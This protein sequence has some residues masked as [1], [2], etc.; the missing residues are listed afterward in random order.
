MKKQNIRKTAE[1]A[2]LAALICLATFIVLNYSPAGGYINLGDCFV[3]IAGWFVG[4]L[5][6]GAAAAVGSVLTDIFLGAPQYIPA[7]FIVKWGIAAVAWAVARLLRAGDKRSDIPKYLLSAICGE[8]IMVAGYFG[9]EI[10]IYGIAGAVAGVV[11]NLIQAGACAVS[12]AIFSVPVI[13]I[14]NRQR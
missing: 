9:Y 5:W 6:G 10:I 14:K 1:S 13:K 8:L 7:T 11:P 12:A 4:P 3:L 2:L